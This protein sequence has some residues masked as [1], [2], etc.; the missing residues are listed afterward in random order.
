MQK[1]KT[2]LIIIP[3]S[4]IYPPLNGGMQRCFHILHQLSLHF[5]VTALVFQKPQEF[6]KAFINYPSLKDVRFIYISNS[7]Y[8]KSSNAVIKRLFKAIKYRGIKKTFFDPADSNFLFYYKSL[9]EILLSNSYDFAVLENLSSLKAASIIRKY[10]KKIKVIYDAHNFDTELAFNDYRKGLIS[11]KI[12][13]SIQ[14]Q[15]E[16][17]YKQV[18]AIWVCSEREKILYAKA[19]QNR[20]HI[21]VVPN[22]VEIGPL[23]NEAISKNTNPVLLFVGS[24]NYPPNTEGLS[25]FIEECWPMLIKQYPKLILNIV[26]SGEMPLALTN[27]IELHKSII[28]FGRVEMI[29]DYYNKATCV[30]VPILTGSGTRL[31]VLEAMAMGVPVVS[32]PKGAEGIDYTES[33]HILIGANP[34]E[35][36]EHVILLLLNKLARKNISRSARNNLKMKYDWIVIGNNLAKSLY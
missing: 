31:K 10:Q 8:P 6:K 12:F 26:G 21:T 5:N 23:H 22:G 15:E 36:V 3:Y 28:F 13:S 34:K 19:N 4:H 29:E 24:M 11:R 30:I 33:K 20:L 2:V 27:K 25:W 32:T 16:L 17:L 9:K 35:L 1:L 14:K 7:E 18:D